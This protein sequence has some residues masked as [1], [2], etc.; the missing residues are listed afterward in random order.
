MKVSPSAVR[1]LLAA[2]VVEG[3]RII[4]TNQQGWADMKDRQL[5]DALKA[6]GHEYVPLPLVRWPPRICTGTLLTLSSGHRSRSRAA[7]KGVRVGQLPA[8]QRRRRVQREPARILLGQCPCAHSHE[9][10]MGKTDIEFCGRQTLPVDYEVSGPKNKETCFISVRPVD[11][12]D[13]TTINDELR[14]S[15][16]LEKMRPIL[17]CVDHPIFGPQDIDDLVQYWEDKSDI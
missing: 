10:R 12:T 4:Q 1:L 8:Q 6:A 7:A 16:I 13:L 3:T 11:V 17:A 14:Q 9:I 5:T 15:I 2:T